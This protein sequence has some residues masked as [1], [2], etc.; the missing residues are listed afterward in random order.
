[1]NPKACSS[2]RQAQRTQRRSAAPRT[3]TPSRPASVDSAAAPPQ[4]APALPAAFA[5]PTRSRRSSQRCNGPIRNLG[6]RRITHRYPST[7]TA[8][9]ATRTAAPATIAAPSKPATITSPTTKISAASPTSAVSTRTSP[10]PSPVGPPTPDP[11]TRQ[12]R[13]LLAGPPA[14]LPPGLRAPPKD[15]GPIST[16]NDSVCM[17]FPTP[18]NRDRTASGFSYPEFRCEFTQVARYPS[19]PPPRLIKSGSVRASSIPPRTH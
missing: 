18:N 2:P 15:R 14:P 6:Q 19:P 10:D 7:G 8:R 16:T 9:H 12:D 17:E 4:P 5:T 1:M 11:C 13:P 3:R